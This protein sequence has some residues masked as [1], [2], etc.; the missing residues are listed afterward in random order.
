MSEGK[1]SNL[2]TN[3]GEPG[4]NHIMTS[5]NDRHAGNVEDEIREGDACT[6]L[7]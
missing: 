1:Q 4:A 7:R 5:S 3:I 6:P 2:K